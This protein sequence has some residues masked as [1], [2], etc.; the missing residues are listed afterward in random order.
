MGPI[1]SVPGGGFHHVD[2]GVNEAGKREEAS[3]VHSV[4]AR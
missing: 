4:A 1:F 2:V 3:G